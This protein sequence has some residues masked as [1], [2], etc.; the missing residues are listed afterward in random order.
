[1]NTF[2]QHINEEQDITK[3][4]SRDLSNSGKH[5]KLNIGFSKFL[6]M[7]DSED[8]Q[9]EDDIEGFPFELWQND[10]DLSDHIAKIVK[11]GK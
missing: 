3:Y 8:F 11:K 9:D 5:G 4:S 1:M 7:D 10:Q 6:Y 2:T